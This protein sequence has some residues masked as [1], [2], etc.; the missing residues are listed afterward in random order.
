MHTPDFTVE[1]VAKIAEFKPLKV[2]FRDSG[3]DSD[4]TKINTAQA[5]N[6]M[7]SETVVK[8]IKGKENRGGNLEERHREHRVF[9]NNFQFMRM[10]CIGFTT[11]KKSLD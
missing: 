4:E 5:F 8:T 1:N 3:F 9:R 11:G 2:V 7:P 6:Q 10:P